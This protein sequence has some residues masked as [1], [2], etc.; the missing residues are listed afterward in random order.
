[1]T[2]RIGAMIEH[3]GQSLDRIV[4][5]ALLGE[6][7]GVDS[8]WLTHLPGQ[9]DT[10]TLAA[11]VAAKTDRV[12]VGTAITPTY[13]RP[14]VVMAQ[15]AITLDEMSGNRLVLG[16]GRGH[17]MFGE[18]MV[19]GTYAASTEPMREY[20][21][22]VTSVIR[23]GDAS[24]TGRFHRGQIA[25]GC[26]RNPD[27]PVFVGAFGP[28]ML[29]LAGELA[30]GVLLWLC[31][32]DYVRDVALPGL[33]KGWARRP[34]GSAGFEV[35]A[36]VSATVTPEPEVA[37]AATKRMMTGYLRME[38]YQKLLS[39]SGFVDEVRTRQ[40]SDAM[41]DALSVAGG[42]G[43]VRDRIDDYLAAGATGVMLSPMLEDETGL[44]RF[45]ATMEA[46]V[47]R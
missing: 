12:A 21:T 6:K 22:I 45:A 38:N 5:F 32:P 11:G 24:F 13:T 31:T 2:T 7:I 42:A 20:L 15:T 40:A 44:A 39:A 16:L 41:V 9:R 23:N 34:G 19:G 35:V 1:M 25:F 14:P 47:N 4:E 10:L 36:T 29:E 8:L 37:H 27:L 46:A 43:E 30:D 28:K 33:R 3:A 17:E 18:W 26:P